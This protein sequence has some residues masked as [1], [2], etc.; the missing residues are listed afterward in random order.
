MKNIKKPSQIKILAITIYSMVIFYS[1]NNPSTAVFKKKNVVDS[2][3]TKLPFGFNTI[4]THPFPEKWTVPSDSTGGYIEPL[5]ENEILLNKTAKYYEHLIKLK[6]IVAPKI[7]TIK[8]VNIDNDSLMK[9]SLKLINNSFKLRLPNFGPYECYYQHNDFSAV[10]PE[11]NYNDFGNIIL[12]NPTKKSANVLNVYH[13]GVYSGEGNGA[14]WRFFYI[15]NDKKILLFNAG[16]SEGDSYLH[17][18]HEISVKPDG[19]ILIK[20]FN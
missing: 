15:S 7:N 3:I 9:R 17:K 10:D 13:L 5:P 14:Y 19:K 11:G 1:C 6:S 2:N 16:E 8:Y 18:S 20:N 12:F 4:I